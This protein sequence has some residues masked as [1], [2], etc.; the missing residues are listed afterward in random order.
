MS[1]TFNQ[2]TYFSVIASIVSVSAA[3]TDGVA[4]I[5]T[6]SGIINKYTSNSGFDGMEIVI[7]PSNKVVISVSINVHFG[8]NIPDVVSKLQE[9]IKKQVESQTGYEVK[10][11]NVEVVGVVFPA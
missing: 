8:Y 1:S 11:V 5:S 4:S 9:L 2:N 10:A 3:K 7:T 6:E